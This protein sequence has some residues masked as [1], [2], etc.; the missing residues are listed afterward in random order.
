MTLRQQLKID[1][2][3][4][5]KARQTH[6]V[7]SLRIMLAAI[8]NAEAVEMDSTFNPVRGRT[9]DVPRKILTEKQILQI[10]QTEAE[11]Q[12]DALA[13]FERLGR[14]EAAKQ[15]RAELEVMSQYLADGK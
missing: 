15:V 13:E 8:D 3:Q 5:M 14:V 10:L 1:L 7:T 2:T 9:N 4:A 11:K 12:Q 6:A